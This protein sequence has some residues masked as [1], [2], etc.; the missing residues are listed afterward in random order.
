MGYCFYTTF[1]ND[2]RDHGI[3]EG[4]PIL[5]IDC[6]AEFHDDEEMKNKMLIQVI[7]L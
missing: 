3:M 2:E 6:N 4:I 1:S 5:E 7:Y